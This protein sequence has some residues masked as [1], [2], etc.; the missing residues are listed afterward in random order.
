LRR[1]I[2]REIGDPLAVALLEGR[3]KEGDTVRIDVDRDR[4]V[5]T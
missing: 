5:L 2:Q 3:Y 4:L 1:V